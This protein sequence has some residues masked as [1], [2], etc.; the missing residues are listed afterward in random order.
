LPVYYFIFIETTDLPFIGPRSMNESFRHLL[1]WGTKTASIV[2]EIMQHQ[3]GSFISLRTA[4][5]PFY[6]TSK[7]S[8]TNQR[9]HVF[10]TNV[11]PG[12]QT[13][14]TAALMARTHHLTIKLCIR[15]SAPSLPALGVPYSPPWT[16]LWVEQP[17]LASFLFI[18]IPPG[19][20]L[21]WHHPFDPL[22]PTRNMASVGTIRNC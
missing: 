20:L 1:F 15:T 9:R 14:V 18:S 10:P 6:L 12:G 22:T 5:P 17:S 4:A 8:W 11:F 21:S 19:D 13:R 16:W 3:S 7:K 2:T